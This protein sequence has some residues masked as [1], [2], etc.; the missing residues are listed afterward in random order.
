[1][2]LSACPS[3]R[4]VCQ[5]LNVPVSEEHESD[6]RASS[7]LTAAKAT[8]T[9]PSLLSAW[10]SRQGVGVSHL[11]TPSSV[12]AGGG[13]GRTLMSGF[14]AAGTRLAAVEGGNVRGS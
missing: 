11:I 13:M 9:S 7:H 14:L 12:L 5:G 2:Y 8:S 10:V 4:L 3:S 1:M 6:S